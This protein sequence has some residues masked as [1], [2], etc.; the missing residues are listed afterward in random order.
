MKENV[1]RISQTFDRVMTVQL[2]TGS[3]REEGILAAFGK[4]PVKAMV[5]TAD[6]NVLKDTL[7]MAR[8]A[9]IRLKAAVP[10]PD[11]LAHVYEAERWRRVED[12]IRLG[13]EAGF[14]VICP[15][16]DAYGYAGSGKENAPHGS[17]RS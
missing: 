8:Q 12:R 17:G 5:Y 13:K 1:K 4:M 15:E 7:R 9:G 10:G 11:F 2:L 16:K 6:R 14:I 3:V